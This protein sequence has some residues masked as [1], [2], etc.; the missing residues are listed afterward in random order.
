MA[1]LLELCYHLLGNLLLSLAEAGKR[2]R[3]LELH[4]ADDDPDLEFLLVLNQELRFGQCKTAFV[5]V[6]GQALKLTLTGG[7]P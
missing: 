5:E 3:Q 7:R 6:G 1:V 2:N 4:F